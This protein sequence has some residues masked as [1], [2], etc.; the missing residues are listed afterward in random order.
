MRHSVVKGGK[1]TGK[2]LLT[3]ETKVSK[4]NFSLE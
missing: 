3:I 1:F 2:L 4:T